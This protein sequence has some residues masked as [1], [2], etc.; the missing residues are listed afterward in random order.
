MT[1]YVWKEGMSPEVEADGAYWER[2]MLALHFA[3]YANEAYKSYT[4]LLKKMGHDKNVDI[5]DYLPCGWYDHGEWEGWS[6]VV[7]LFDGRMTFHIPDDFDLGDKLP[8]IEP[9]WNGHTTEDK[10][11]RSMKKCGCEI[12]DLEK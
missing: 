7:S 10:W 9:N 8:Q 11:L 6:R 4:D 1:P 3:V 2:N 5:K 12:P